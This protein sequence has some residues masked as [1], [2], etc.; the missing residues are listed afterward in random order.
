MARGNSSFRQ[1]ANNKADQTKH[2]NVGLRSCYAPYFSHSS[3]I[4]I[5]D[6]RTAGVIR[7]KKHAFLERWLSGLRQRL[8]KAAM[9]PTASEV[10]ILPLSAPTE[11]FRPPFSLRISRRTCLV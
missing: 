10:R 2:E 5:W 8:E 6:L 9:R 1:M 3:S 4:F 11:R 7:R